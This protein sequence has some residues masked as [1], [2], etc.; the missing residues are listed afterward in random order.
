MQTI[1]IGFTNFY[2]IDIFGYRDWTPTLTLFLIMVL[3]RAYILIVLLWDYHQKK[4]PANSTTVLKYF[5]RIGINVVVGAGVIYMFVNSDR[6]DGQ[7]IYCQVWAFCNCVILVT[8]PIFMILTILFNKK[9]S[10]V[11]KIDDLFTCEVPEDGN[12]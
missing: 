11:I 12:N 2:W 9:Y 5:I 4:H 8:E 3:H 10:A 1:F 7:N 6:L